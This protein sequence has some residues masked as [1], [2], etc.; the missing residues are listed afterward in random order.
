MKDIT[1]LRY[2]TTGL[3]TISTSIDK[4]GSIVEK[5]YEENYVGNPFFI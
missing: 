4:I 1:I 5:M 3:E 2:Q